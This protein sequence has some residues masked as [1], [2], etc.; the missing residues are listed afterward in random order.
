MNWWESLHQ[1]GFTDI[2]IY[3]FDKTITFYGAAAENRVA[4]WNTSPQVLE[5]YSQNITLMV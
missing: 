5:K 1:T 4:S 3:Y 2:A